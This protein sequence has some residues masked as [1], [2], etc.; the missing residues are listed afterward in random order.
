MHE[1]RVAGRRKRGA[2]QAEVITALPARSASAATAV[3]HSVVD[4]A[5][6]L[7]DTNHAAIDRADAKAGAVVAACGVSAAALVAVYSAHRADTAEVSF[8]LLCAALALAS[9]SCAGL[10]LRPR[11]MRSRQ[12]DSLIFFDHVTRMADSSVEGYIQSA[13]SLFSDEEELTTEITRQVWMT[14]RLATV[15]YDWI[16]RAVLLL[17]GNLLALGVTALLMAA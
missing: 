2:R 8:A 6:R 10:A 16:D 3:A 11:R 7:L 5:W 17:F 4:R 13:R 12:P 14:A 1:R 9:T 15:K